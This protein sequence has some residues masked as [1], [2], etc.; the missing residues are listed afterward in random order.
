VINLISA[1][2]AYQNLEQLM[3]LNLKLTP[4]LGS[5]VATDGS[6]REHDNDKLFAD[7]KHWISQITDKHADLFHPYK[8][9]P[10]P[11]LLYLRTRGILDIGIILY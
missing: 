8:G 10:P 7:F 2:A 1:L 9:V 5:D 4:D 11:L 3:F 6:N